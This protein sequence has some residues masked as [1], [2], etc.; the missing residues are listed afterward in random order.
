MSNTKTDTTPSDIA[1]LIT[2]SELP[3]LAELGELPPQKQMQTI[4]HARQITTAGQ[5]YCGRGLSALKASV[6]CGEYLQLLE[7]HGWQPRTAQ[8]YT[9]FAEFA[10]FIE[11]NNATALSHLDMTGWL[12]VQAQLD[13]K[14]L[15]GFIQ[16]EEVCGITLDNAQ[17]KSS[18]ELKA[19][20]EEHKNSANAEISRQQKEIADLQARLESSEIEKDAAKTQLMQKTAFHQFSDLV[21]ATRHEAG[22]MTDKAMLCI[23][24]LTRMN[25]DLLEAAKVADGDDINVALT[26]LYTHVNALFAHTQ[27]LKTQMHS[28]WGSL[29]DDISVTGE[30][31]YSDQE[32]DAAISSRELLVRD[33]EQQKR[34]RSNERED[35]K[36]RGRG[37]PKKQ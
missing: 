24:D 1:L 19:A 3:T 25:S 14:T 23:D 22:A 32:I 10:V 35:G 9:K 13:E 11:K 37:R 12:T 36:P 33:H 34:F 20:F 28:R 17:E 29:A 27:K 18:R 7:E 15:L 5:V 6:S 30:V 26:S 16:G 31:L 2:K 8:R 21:M 4:T